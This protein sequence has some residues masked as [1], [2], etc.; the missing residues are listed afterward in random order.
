M[1]GGAIASSGG[2]AFAQ[3][4]NPLRSCLLSRTIPCNRRIPP[5]PRPDSGSSAAAVSTNQMAEILNINP[6]IIQIL[7]KYDPHTVEKL[8]L[9]DVETLNNLEKLAPG[10]KL[11]LQLYLQQQ[12]L[13]PQQPNQPVKSY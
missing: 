5:P 13:Q 11:R 7:E 6:Q 3:T 2:Q 4:Q 1:V 10:S 9:G 8:L 12:K